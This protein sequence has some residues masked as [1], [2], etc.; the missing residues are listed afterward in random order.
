MINYP[1]YQREDV[2]IANAYFTVRT[3]FTIKKEVP[4]EIEKIK[5][6]KLKAIIS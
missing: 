6:K 3:V 4:L 5:I 1:L 2:S